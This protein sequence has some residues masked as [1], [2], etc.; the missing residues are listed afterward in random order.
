MLGMPVN[1]ENLVR[2][3]VGYLCHKI[4]NIAFVEIRTQVAQEMGQMFFRLL[5]LV[6]PAYFLRVGFDQCFTNFKKESTE[7]YWCGDVRFSVGA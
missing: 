6:M 5:F 1:T 7:K 2:K 4:E 3:S